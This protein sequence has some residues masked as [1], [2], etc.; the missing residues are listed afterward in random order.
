MPLPS[1]PLD[2]PALVAMLARRPDM[3]KDLERGAAKLV[4]EGKLEPA[5]NYVSPLPSSRRAARRRKNTPM[6]THAVHPQLLFE[7]FEVHE[8][9]GPTAHVTP[10]N[11]WEKL[12]ERWAKRKAEAQ[13]D[14]A[15]PTKTA[16]V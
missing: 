9:T 12:Q 15:P 16:R 11:A 7:N 8:L 2:D 4:Q 14:A 1:N 13:D 6:V 5:R 3:L 10:H